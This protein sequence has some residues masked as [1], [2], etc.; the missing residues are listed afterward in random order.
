M[1]RVFSQYQKLVTSPADLALCRQAISI[2]ELLALLKQLWQ[3]EQFTDEELIVQLQLCNQTPLI[4]SMDELANCWIPYHYDA[5]TRSI[6]WCLPDGRATEPFHDQFISRSR[7]RIFLNQLLTPRTALSQTTSDHEFQP[8]GFIFHLSR[9]GS[10]LVSGSFAE[11]ECV[12]V[13]SESPLLTEFLLDPDL[14]HE[15][16]KQYLPALIRLQGEGGQTTARQVVI[17]WNAWDI[18]YWPMIRALYPHTPVVLLVRDPLEIL[19]SHER[20]AGRHMAGDP[21]MASFHPVFN[22][23]ADTQLLD[24]RIE[25]LG[26]LLNAMVDIANESGVMVVDYR[27]LN[28]VKIEQIAK[29]FGI[30]PTVA[31]LDLIKQRLQ[32][33]SKEPERQFIPD[34]LQKQQVFNPNEKVKIRNQLMSPYEEL[35]GSA[36]LST[37]NESSSL[38]SNHTIT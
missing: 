11:I 35:L 14:T 27:Q 7:Q 19:A 9:C 13:L 5:K 17:K 2:S 34:S 24:F 23:S 8:A 16:K 20:S 25:V 22:K 15:E 33:H 21:A 4:V 12:N 3:Q 30:A 26:G 38:N 18:F 6:L 10:T 36:I 28:A 29:H 32:R 1:L 37:K 31:E